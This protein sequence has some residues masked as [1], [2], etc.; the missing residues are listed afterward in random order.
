MSAISIE[1]WSSKQQQQAM[2]AAVSQIADLS[3]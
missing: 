3:G 1:S 2:F